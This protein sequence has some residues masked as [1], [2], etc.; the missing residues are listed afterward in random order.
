MVELE[1]DDATHLLDLSQVGPALLGYDGVTVK[2]TGTVAEDEDGWEVIV[3][4]S[5]TEV[6]Q[7]A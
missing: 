1:T 2:I 6:D 3:V 4:T 5:F 7:A